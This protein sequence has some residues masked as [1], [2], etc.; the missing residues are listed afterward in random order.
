[1]TYLNTPKNETLLTSSVQIAGR[2]LSYGADGKQPATVKLA[3]FILNDK[4]KVVK[5]FG[6]QLSVKPLNTGET[7]ATGI[8]YNEHTPLPPGIY[9]VRVAARDEQSGRVG[10]AL[11]WVVIPD[12]ATRQLSTSSVLLGGQVLENTKNKDADPQ[13]Q[14]SVD[15]RFSRLTRLGYWLFVY[16]AKRDAAG[17]PS[18]TAQTQVLRDGRVVLASPQRKLNQGG[19]DPERIPF[20]EELA[21]RTLTPGKY[22]LRVTVTDSLAGASITQTVDFE[23][24]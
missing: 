13:I 15:H 23:V 6:N 14:L 7:D 2:G 10:S 21:L 16:N 11:Q 9:Q 22:D 5:G 17:A 18:L 12:L 8:I 4:G 1:L 20:G 24:Q 19:S 3:G